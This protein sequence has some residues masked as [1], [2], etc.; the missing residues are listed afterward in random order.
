MTIALVTG[1]ARGIGYALSRRLSEAGYRL[2][3]VDMSS[4]IYDSAAVFG[5]VAVQADISEPAGREAI[6]AAVGS[7]GQPLQLL[8]NNAGIT[9]DALIANMTEEAF[10][11]VLRVNLG[12]CY[13]LTRA[14]ADNMA[15]G[16]SIVNISSRASL[17]NVGQFNYATSKAAVIGLTRSLALVYAPRLRVNAVAPGFIATEMTDAMPDRVRERIIERVPL[18]RAGQPED[19]AEA[20]TWL[21]SEKAGYVTGQVLYSCGGRTHG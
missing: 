13:E 4:E 6:A 14:L 7:T 18:Q 8:V 5:A 12:G 21:G 17:G 11:L 15:D 20:V 2:V 3:M 1:A 9:R 10:R 19:I 16:G